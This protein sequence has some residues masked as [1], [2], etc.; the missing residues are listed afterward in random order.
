MRKTANNNTKK[1]VAKSKNSKEK[2][3]EAKQKTNFTTTQNENTK[4][5]NITKN[6]N[7]KEK[8]D[9][10]KEDKTSKE[11]SKEQAKIETIRKELKSKNKIPIKDMNKIYNAIFPNIY[12]AAGVI[13]YFLF[14]IFGFY[15]INNKVFITDVKAFSIAMLCGAIAIF[16]YAYKKDSTKF[17]IYGIEML[18]VALATLFIQYIYF[19]QTETI[20]R[21]YMLIPLAFAI[22]Y[23]LKSIILAT[24]I[25]LA[26][27]NNISD[28]KEIIKKE[29]KL[30]IEEPTE[31]KDSIA[32]STK[33]EKQYKLKQ[34][35]AKKNI[36]SKNKKDQSKNKAKEKNSKTDGEKN[37]KTTN[38]K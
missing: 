27:K 24:K 36:F 19:Y 1:T 28:V 35:S 30:N 6:K 23:V 2:K 20:I 8:K 22:Y 12:I 10:L 14:M 17:A 7:I 25:K 16:E 26:N 29:K 33:N 38:K 34:N 3:A 11:I 18:F 15:N 13:I 4:K 9:I 21:L 32:N 31:D 37:T 5:K